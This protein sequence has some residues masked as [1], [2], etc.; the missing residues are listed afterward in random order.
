MSLLLSTT[1]QYSLIYTHYLS[2]AK[3]RTIVLELELE[4][5][6]PRRSQRPG[7]PDANWTSIKKGFSP[8][9]RRRGHSFPS[10]P[11]DACEAQSACR[12]AS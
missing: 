1:P 7:M 8:P 6:A 10:N 3:A 11:K 4:A 2:R 12:R 9:P 5:G